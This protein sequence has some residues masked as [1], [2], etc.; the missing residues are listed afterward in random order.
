MT[1]VL[2]FNFEPV[3]PRAGTKQHECVV[4][5]LW[6]KKIKIVSALKVSWQ[7]KASQVKLASQ[8]K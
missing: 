8:K 3:K 1:G 2:L 6:Q 7:G 5:L 4:V